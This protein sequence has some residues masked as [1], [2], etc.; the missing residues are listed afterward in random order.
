VLIINGGSSSLKFAVF[1]VDEP[2]QEVLSGNLIAS[3]DPMP[4]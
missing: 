3:A 1:R 2:L 4:R